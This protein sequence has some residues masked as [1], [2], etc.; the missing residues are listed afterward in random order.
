[1]PW[2]FWVIFLVLGVLVPWRGRKRLQHLLALPR[3]E[4]KEKLALYGWTIAFQWALLGVVAW[5]AFAR[6]LTSSQ[7]GLAGELSLGLVCISLVGGAFLGAVQW[8]NLRRVSRTSGPIPELM[9]KLAARLLPANNLELAPYCALSLTAGVCEEFLYR[10]FAM[11]A[12]SRAGLVTW[13]VVV[14]TSI[15]FG[16]AHAYQ[17]RSG[18][19]G[20]TLMGFILA[21]CRVWTCSLIPGMVWHSAVD[22]T[23]GIAG[24]KYFVFEQP[25]K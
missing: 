7:L 23:A 3:V 20:T 19:I 14:V 22:I 16:L 8:F 18:I 5:R 17:G 11:A 13:A 21:G 1:M 6:G 2:D 10:G 9:R 4:A 24:P 25:G 15:L 12:L